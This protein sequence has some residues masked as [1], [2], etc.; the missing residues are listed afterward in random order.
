MPVSHKLRPSLFYT[1]SQTSPH[2]N[3]ALRSLQ[4]NYHFWS[5]IVMN[6][7]IWVANPWELNI[8]SSC[9]DS[10]G[11]APSFE[12][13]LILQKGSAGSR[14]HSGHLY[15]SFLFYYH[16]QNFIALCSPGSIWCSPRPHTAPHQPQCIASAKN[17]RPKTAQNNTYALVFVLLLLFFFGGVPQKLHIWLCPQ[18][19]LPIHEALVARWP[20]STASQ[21]K[22]SKCPSKSKIS[23]TFSEGLIYLLQKHQKSKFPSF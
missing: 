6:Y 2:M 13:M 15:F 12:K 20:M 16:Q 18:H 11:I 7:K 9:H 22:A 17:G 23:T 5:E 21:P 19:I 3:W 10:E 8:F 4:S 14:Q 1:Q